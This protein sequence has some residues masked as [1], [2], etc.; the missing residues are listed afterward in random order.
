MLL[1][2][3]SH[4]MA[5]SVH[6]NSFW[7]KAQGEEQTGHYLDACKT[8]QKILDCQDSIYN[9]T[10]SKT[11]ED[12]SSVY[13]VED[14]K[15][16]S[17]KF[18]AKIIFYSALSTLILCVVFLVGLFILKK[19]NRVLSTSMQTLKEEKDSAEK[20]IQ[21][22]SFF[23][24]N[25]S[26]EIRSPLNAIVGFSQILS[27]SEIDASTKKQCEDAI[28][29]N[30]ELLSRLF[31]DVI[32]MSLTDTDHMILNMAPC[33]VVDLC[34]KVVHTMSII[35]HTS[36]EIK[37]A[38]SLDTLILNTDVNRLQQV[39][40][41]LMVNAT[42]Y[43]KEGEILLDLERVDNMAQFSVSDTGCGIK[44][45]NKQ[46][47]DRFEKV[48][49]HTQGSG[50]GLSI[51]RS[52]IVQLGGN[53]SIDSKYTKGARFVFTHPIAERSVK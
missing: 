16:E 8:Y 13:R 41:N 43:T 51:C 39:L 11:I 26:H 6:F 9:R 47:F 1:L 35:K 40:I 44:D 4:I 49:E 22:K 36:A 48:S 20:T 28:K 24:A 32:N 45:A 15:R 17:N 3:T 30:S 10:Y 53:I 37:F 33:D 27:M 34:R 23:L 46:L 21:S 19:A 29:M 50:L 38:T 31:S 25:M 12:L 42:K 7:Q 18:K 5:N 2:F 52:I 14:L